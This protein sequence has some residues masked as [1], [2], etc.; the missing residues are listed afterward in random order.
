MKLP[1]KFGKYVLVSKIA[2][3][4]MA[5]IYRAKY[6]GESGFEKEVA[7]KRI[8]PVWSEDRSF[9]TMLR[10]EAFALVNLQHQNIVQVY[11]LG[12][13]GDAFF[14][15]MEYVDGADLRKVFKK[16]GEGILPLK[17]TCFIIA[18]ILKALDFA[19]NKK[20]KDQRS[21]NI[22]HRDVSPQNV[23]ISFNGEVKVAD[24]GIAKGAH[25]QKETTVVQVKGKYA[26]MSPEQAT[27]APVDART[28][29]YAVGVILFELLTGKR[30]YDSQN[31][32]QTIE[33]VK[34]SALPDGWDEYVP[35]D[36][37]TIVKNALEKEPSKRFRSAAQFLNEL[38][39]YIFAN[40]LNTSGIELSDHL[41]SLFERE[42]T[43][44][45]IKEEIATVPRTRSA[46]NKFST[47][48]M[49]ALL[50]A[51]FVG[52]FTSGKMPEKFPSAIL[53][54]SSIPQPAVKTFAT[55]NVQARPW[56]Y[57]YLAG[58]AEKKETP[59]SNLKIKAGE[60]LLKIFHEPSN[61]WLQKNIIISSNYAI[62]CI[63]DFNKQN[64]SCKEKR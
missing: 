11:E 51:L 37:Q 10:D 5:E 15:S 52:I 1:H 28:D 47:H 60:H 62:S 56:G 55:L 9:V 7:I 63:A 30:L 57:V 48:Q 35:N 25:R 13:D 45:S 18:E 44:V 59:I 49:R 54:I 6:I 23:L 32:L 61:S 20:D 14:I 39:R 2:Q 53:Q 8:L 64:I 42:N 58:Y 29:I 36:L 3:G 40:N 26:Y 43:A 41:K 46:S 38:N 24:F 22:I 21:L 19:H 27:G 33:Q 12:K 31:E 50:T 17:F 4:G 34:L 16:A